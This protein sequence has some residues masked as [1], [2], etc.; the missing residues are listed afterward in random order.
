MFSV[1]RNILWYVIIAANSKKRL[2]RFFYSLSERIFRAMASIRG[3]LTYTQL[4]M[5]SFLLIILLGAA[6]L[7]LPIASADG[8]GTNFLDCLFTSVSATCVTGLIVVDTCVHWSGFG[9]AV[10][11]FLIQIGGLGVMTCVATIALVFRRRITLGERRLLM[12]SAGSMQLGGM[13]RLIRNIL[14][15]TAAVEGLGAVLLFIAFYPKM[16]FA[17]GLWNAVFH[18]VSAF[19]NAGFDL[20]GKYTPFGSIAG[21]QFAFDPL[22]ILTLSFLIITGGIGFIVWSDVFHHGLHLSRYETHSKIVLAT[23]AALIL[24]GFALMLVS[25]WNGALAGHSPGEKILGALF[26]S[27]S[28]RTA[29]FA[30]VDLAKL[31]QAGVLFTVMLMLIGGSPGSTAGGIKT[32][33]FFV[34]LLGALTSARR[35][36]SI[37]VFKRK[38]EPETVMQ[39]SA[40][41]FLYI[42][43]VTAAV[44]LICIIEPAFSLGQILF[45]CASAMGTSGLTLGITPSLS[46]ASHIILMLLMYS[47]RIGGLSLM[48]VLAENRRDVPLERPTAKI[49]IG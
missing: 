29:G 16:G 11:L 6:L 1:W 2:C 4:I 31:S 8:R 5:L 39:A 22:V 38:L 23:T 18:S 13:V 7:C 3:K 37:T 45:E 35:F 46:T 44:I 49:L 19:C 42:F 30:S 24:G 10:I 28:P 47:G 34:L 33:T 21:S 20:M 12:Q 27:V 36:G 9:Q 17:T 40:V 26:L 32:T 15:V 25:E 41:F 43:T 14:A 48:L